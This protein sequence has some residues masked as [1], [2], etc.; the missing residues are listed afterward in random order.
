MSHPKMGPFA[1]MLL[2]INTIIGAG[3]FINAAPL[4]RLGGS[5]GFVGYL[6]A[7]L[8]MFP[9]ILCLSSFCSVRPQAGGLYI[10]AKEF[11]HPVAGF[12]SGWSYFVGKTMG[13]ALLAHVFVAFFY[14]QSPVMQAIPLFVW[15]CG[16]IFLLAAI[17]SLGVRIGGRIQWLFIA[18][19]VVPLA[20]AMV[21]GWFETAYSDPA[22]IVPEFFELM[23]TLPIAIFAFSSFEVTCTI[24][25]LI[26]DA[27]QNVKRIM[28]GSS[29][30]ALAVYIAFQT[31]LYSA[32]G[33]DLGNVSSPFMLIGQRFFPDTLWLGIFVNRVMFA[34]VVSASFG[35][36]TNN[37]W[38]LQVLARDGFFPKVFAQ[39]ND[40]HVPW[41][42]LVAEAGL[43][44]L[45]LGLTTEQIPLQN[46][47]VMS[48]V[49]C[50]L[51][52]MIAAFKVR[53]QGI[54]EQMPLWISGAGIA[55]CMYIIFLC[56]AKIAQVGLSLPFFM[57][58]GI[59]LL[60]LM[61]QRA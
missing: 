40:A 20:F 26:Q 7:A 37:C 60:A 46:M 12:V 53:W 58:F 22:V 30:V 6:F 49:T 15:D 56:T 10:Y 4:T 47:A 3:V 57:V 42:S 13:A 5:L 24:A 28:I 54:S 33:A 36:L 61:R 51:I 44:C 43:A 8:A 38:N 35:I 9:V 2:S 14:R 1:A 25:H 16:L 55:S 29:L 52:N 45:V 50:Y 18:L 21:A 32:L 59:G 11:L 39:I 31:S 19:K 27:E 48:F 34:S 17:N 41:V 23:R